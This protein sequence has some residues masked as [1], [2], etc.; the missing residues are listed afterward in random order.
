M[1]TFE[2]PFIPMGSL[3]GRPTRQQI[4]RVLSEYADAGITQYLV[5]PRSGCEMEY[6]SE[7][8]MTCMENI[9]REAECLHFTSLWLYDEFNW[10]SG[11]CGGRVPAENPAYAMPY[12]CAIRREGRIQVELRRNE[13]MTDLMNPDAV[14]CFIRLTH[15]RYYERLK[16]WFGT[17]IK[18][19][20][21]DEPEIGYFPKQPDP[22]AIFHLAYYEGLEQDYHALTG[23]DLLRDI[24]GGLRASPDFHPT[25][26]SELLAKR[27]RTCY[28]DRIRAWCDKHGILLTGH[29]M[30]ETTPFTARKSNG[31]ILQVLSGF[32]LP[33]MDEIHTAPTLDSFEWLTFGTGMYAIEKRGNGGLAELF[34][35]GPCDL[36]FARLNKMLFLAAAFGVDHYLLATA[37]VD[38]RGKSIKTGWYNVFGIEQPHIAV[39]KYWQ[40]DGLRAARLA[41]RKRHFEVAVRYGTQTMLYLDLLRDLTDRQI[42]WRL[43]DQGEEVPKDVQVVLAIAPDGTIYDELHGWKGRTFRMLW[44]ASLSRILRIS[45]RFLT[46]EGDLAGDLFVR[47]YQDGAVLAVDMSGRPRDLLL[48]RN[49]NSLRFHLP[50]H[51]VQLFPG[52]RL[53]YDRPHL[54]RVHFD[55]AG[56][57][58]LELAQAQELTLALRDYSGK[59]EVELDGKPLEAMPG[60]QEL[61]QGFQELY[62]H[63][64]LGRLSAGVHLL[65]CK[66][67]AP[68]YPFLPQAIWIGEDLPDYVG[69]VKQTATMLIPPDAASASLPAIQ[70][71]GSAELM[72]DGVSLGLRLQEPY[73]WIIPAELRGREVEV[74][75]VRHTSVGGLFG[76]SWEVKDEKSRWQQEILA[77]K[78]IPIRPL[79]IILD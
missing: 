8:Y 68:E 12:L 13:G 40:N 3:T 27:F 29:L 48:D 47:R 74:T 10:P 36:S 6:L 11:R 34:A 50:A 42:S 35:L 56:E 43:L 67:E 59:V 76:V 75:L 60:C 31:R 44:N 64:S 2:N 9:C 5:Y 37:P 62:G 15:E 71:P 72:M 45:S 38:A 24:E 49:G 32:S 23:G 39:W 54:L 55:D 57:Y 17:L 61:P 63:V 70:T 4:Q 73:K 77:P 14:D 46:Q 16:P 58:R 52:W 51:G 25:V 22:E 18:G 20:F 69:T 66:G 78:Q 53:E 30:N 1:Q 65:K 21:T 79:D 19:I 26:C 28:V 7:E 33:G 41:G